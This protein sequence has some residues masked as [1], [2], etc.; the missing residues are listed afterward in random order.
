MTL[1][2]PSVAIWR[3]ASPRADGERIEARGS[4]T[5]IRSQKPHPILSLGKGEANVGVTT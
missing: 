2:M 4:T 5:G 3:S 1:H